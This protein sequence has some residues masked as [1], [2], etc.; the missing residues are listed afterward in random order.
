MTT[1]LIT[2]II[3]ILVVLAFGIGQIVKSK[4]LNTTCASTGETCSCGSGS[5]KT[6]D[7]TEQA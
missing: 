4:P 3:L 7:N 5:E 1:T 6:C 2:F